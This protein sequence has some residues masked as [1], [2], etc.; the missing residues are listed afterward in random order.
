MLTVSLSNSF[1]NKQELTPHCWL[2]FYATDVS[3][4]TFIQHVTTGSAFCPG[5]FAND[6]RKDENFLSAELIGVDFDNNVSVET[7]VNH[8]HSN[9]LWMIYATPSST[10]EN[11]KSRALIKLN[12]PITDADEYKTLVRA[13]QDIFS[14]LQPDKATKDAARLFFGSDTTDYKVMGNVVSTEDIKKLCPKT[15][16]LPNPV[17]VSPVKTT[18]IYSGKE[19]LKPRKEVPSIVELKNTLRKIPP[20]DIDYDEWLS[21]LMAIHWCYPNKYGLDIAKHWTSHSCYRGELESK[22]QSFTDDKGIT[23]ATIYALAKKFTGIGVR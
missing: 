13:V 22:W 23:V 3:E 20:D 15:E 18:A 8:K 5:V 11:P 21:V 19:L 10:K 14:D 4:E 6:H 2:S 12:K 1:Y 17:K 9:L 7:L 16:S